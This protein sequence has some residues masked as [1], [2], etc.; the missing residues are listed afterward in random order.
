MRT[1][2]CRFHKSV[3]NK[4]TPGSTGKNFPVEWPEFSASSGRSPFDSG[5]KTAR[6]DRLSYDR[7]NQK[8]GRHYLR[9]IPSPGNLTKTRKDSTMM[10][11]LLSLN[12][13]TGDNFPASGFPGK[14]IKNLFLLHHSNH[15]S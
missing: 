1:Y 5:R 14:T 7:R 4:G 13:K 6:D 12:R 10:Q 3:G 2:Y 15:Y 11:K 8:T 9:K